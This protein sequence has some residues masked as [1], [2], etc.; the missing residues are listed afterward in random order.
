MK[1]DEEIIKELKKACPGTL[2]LN[3]CKSELELTREECI[4]LNK[5]CMDLIDEKYI[6]KYE[7][8]KK[9]KRLDETMQLMQEVQE[10]NKKVQEINVR[11]C[12]SLKAANR[13]FFIAVALLLICIIALVFTM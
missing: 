4:R 7:L 9:E 10:A 5:S 3:D 6:L 1:S 2:D 12:N 11:L 13:D 8:D